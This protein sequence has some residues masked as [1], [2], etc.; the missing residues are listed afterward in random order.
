MTI[1]L[2][3]KSFTVEEY[4]KLGE[5][6]II[7]ATDKVELINGDIIT[8]NPIKSLH[9]GMVD[10]LIEF[11]I[12]NLYKKATIKCQNPI[13]LSNHSEPEPDIVIAHYRADSYS[14][15]HPTPKDIH[16]VIEVSDSTLEKD[17][18][19]K[20][21][22]YAKAKIPEYWI[23]NLTNKQIEVYR[24]PKKGVY[25]SL[26]IISKEEHIDCLTLPFSLTHKD[27]FTI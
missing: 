17:Q 5:L 9:A 26:Q 14:S 7:K 10:F 24:H 22:L 25:S 4:H 20:S 19:V 8:M 6:G 13:Q 18:N 23:I 21:L 16:V 11:L 1:S 2:K 15:R 12:I 27:I 3:R